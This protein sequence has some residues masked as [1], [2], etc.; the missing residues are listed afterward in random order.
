A[1]RSGK[2]LSISTVYHT[3]RAIKDFLSW[4]HGRKE[5]RNRIIPE[6]IDYLSLTL[7]Q[8]RQ[9]Q[10]TV[11]KKYATLEEYR[12]ALFAMPTGTEIERRDQALMALLLLTCM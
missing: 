7:G 12:T 1:V 8:E 5:Y 6:N 3:L 4:L 2:P 9:A 10:T 11:P